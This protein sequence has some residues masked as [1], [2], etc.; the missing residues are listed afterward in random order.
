MTLINI[1][2]LNYDYSKGL[3]KDNQNRYLLGDKIKTADHA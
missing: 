1:N 3:Q 2:H